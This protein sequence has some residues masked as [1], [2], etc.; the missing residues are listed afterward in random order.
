MT[1]I[2]VKSIDCLKIYCREALVCG[3]MVFLSGQLGEGVTVKEQTKSA[4]A[5]IDGLLAKCGTDKSRRVEMTIW[6]ADITR[7]YAL[8]NEAYDD[9]IG[10]GPPPPRAC[11]E[12]KLYSSEY[13]V[14]IRVVASL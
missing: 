5:I 3:D 1:L 2:Y 12:G 11:I 9:W 8:M 7:D 6:L 4:L 10:Q 14:E 13:F